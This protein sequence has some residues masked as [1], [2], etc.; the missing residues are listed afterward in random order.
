MDMAGVALRSI[1]ELTR[2]LEKL[3]AEN[4]MLKQKI[5]ELSRK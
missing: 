3:E 5:E 4:E 1:Q 2:R